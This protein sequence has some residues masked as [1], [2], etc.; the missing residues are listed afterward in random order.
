MGM[1]QKRGEENQISQKKN[2]E[3]GSRDGCLKKRGLESPYKTM[4]FTSTLLQNFFVYFY[5]SLISH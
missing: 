5:L 3:D 4:M 2:G 1:E